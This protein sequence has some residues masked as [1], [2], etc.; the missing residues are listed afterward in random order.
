[1]NIQTITLKNILTS[2][3]NKLHSIDLKAS[4]LEASKSMVALKIGSLLVCN[5]QEICGIITERDILHRVVSQG[6]DPKTCTVEKYMTDRIR[7]IE[8]SSTVEEAMSVMTEQ[9]H[10]HLPVMEGNEIIGIVSSGDLIKHSLIN[11][12]MEVEHLLHYITDSCA[13]YS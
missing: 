12:Q 6:I 7:S 5:R 4:V 10:R 9:R 13:S 11:S 8:S 3:E 2:K 1:M